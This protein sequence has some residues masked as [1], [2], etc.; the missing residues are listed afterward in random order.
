MNRNVMI[1]EMEEKDRMDVMQM[2]RSFYES[3]A[4]FT[5]GSDEIFQNDIEA[6]LDG[7][8]YLEGYVFEEAGEV[9]GYAMLAKSFSTEF[10]RPCIWIEDLY[11]REE[12]RGKGAGGQFMDFV[13]KKYTGCVFR[14]EAEEENRRALHLYRKCGFDELP[15]M[16]L[17]R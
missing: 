16:E 9:L 1:R 12:S 10:G 14:L 7:S 17:K 4:V 8:P 3:P 13:M 11:V 5:S 6:C 2:M 15:Y